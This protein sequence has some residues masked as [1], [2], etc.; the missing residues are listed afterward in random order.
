MFGILN[1]LRSTHDI[2]RMIKLGRHLKF[3]DIFM[4]SH[5]KLNLIS[6]KRDEI[7]IFKN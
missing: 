1:L 5:D 6:D 4:D 7:Q 2:W 3:K